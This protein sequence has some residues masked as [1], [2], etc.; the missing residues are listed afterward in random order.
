MRKLEVNVNNIKSS[1]I[2]EAAEVIFNSGI[3]A[4][5][6][7]TVYGLACRADKPEA[8][9]RL[10]DIKGR[11]QSK[12]FTYSVDNA[13]KAL[14]GYFLI[15]PPFGC[16]IIEKFWP[17]PLTIVYHD[18]GDEKIG[19]RVP[20]H[21]VAQEILKILDVP[22]YLTSANITEQKDAVSANEV[23]A[24]FSGKVDLIIDSGPAQYSQPST[25]VDLTY[26]PFQVLREG[27]ISER[28]IIEVFARKRILFV[29]TGN[30]CRSPMAE[31]L[32]KK[33][34][35]AERPYFQQRYEIISRGVHAF[36]GSPI[37]PAVGDIL[38]N[39]EDINSTEFASKKLD[40]PMLLS[41]DY[42]F[43]MEEAHKDF[44]LNIEPSVE[45][46]I[47]SI[48]KFLPPQDE[49]DIPDPIGASYE[50]YEKVYS[51]IKKAVTELKDWL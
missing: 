16:R 5:P 48:K 17:G 37:A 8:V 39:K 20:A 23:E 34:L 44:I 3:V 13:E 47:F 36:P 1:S 32:L 42:I 21:K 35:A 7:E 27:V 24:I 28:E 2:T 49:N 46:R 26:Y 4:I 22:V 11:P 19:M 41:S 14:T 9:D 40:K 51:I 29:C 30:T 50:T 45:G 25:V 12:V 33:F 31:F 15:L 38:M 43:T 10:Y 6:T 18:K